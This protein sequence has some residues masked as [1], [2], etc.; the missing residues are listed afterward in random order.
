VLI[1]DAEVLAGKDARVALYARLDIE[2]PFV[3]QVDSVTP[4]IHG[5]EGVMCPE[6]PEDPAGSDA[7]Q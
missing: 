1:G 3:H 4:A 7:P 5:Q 2:K 6:I